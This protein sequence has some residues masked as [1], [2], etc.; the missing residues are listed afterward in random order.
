MPRGYVF[1]PGAAKSLYHGVLDGQLLQP[2]GDRLGQPCRGG[3]AGHSRGGGVKLQRRVGEV[4]VVEAAAGKDV[5]RVGEV[6]EHRQ[7][8][9]EGGAGG[10]F[11]HPADPAGD[12]RPLADVVDR[13]CTRQPAHAT[14]LDVHVAAASQGDRLHRPPR[15]RDALI[16]ADGR[17]DLGLKLGVIDQVIVGKA[18]YDGRI[19][20]LEALAC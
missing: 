14:R 1:C 15:V 5:G 3:D 12:A 13:H 17:L 2:L 6:V 8:G 4:L 18:F 16:E 7:G 10:A 19:D 11:E 9:A 20:P